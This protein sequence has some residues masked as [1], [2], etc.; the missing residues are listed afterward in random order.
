MKTFKYFL[1]PFLFVL[2]S[3][4]IYKPYEFKESAMT[5]GTSSSKPTMS[6]LRNDSGKGLNPKDDAERKR[7]EAEIEAKKRGEVGMP[8]NT[9]PNQNN[10]QTP[11]VSP[12][13]KQRTGNS[14]QSRTSNANPEEDANLEQIG[15][16]D[17]IMA[18]DSLK[19]KI[20][21]NKY[22][23][24]TA[25]G[26]QYKIQADQWE[27]DTLVSH[28]LRKPEKVLRFHSN[29]IDEEELME[30][31]FSKPYSDLITVGAYVAGGAAVLLLV[32]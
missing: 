11:S 20:E 6:S 19:I 13:K 24:I 23:K 17:G 8:V 4:Y 29:Q 31:R 15:T 27:G 22:Y 26:K 25:E 32:L 12:D 18:V 28:I 3:C 30:R 7:K 16:T 2:S 1:L 14:S 5:T 9:D 21:P 10:A